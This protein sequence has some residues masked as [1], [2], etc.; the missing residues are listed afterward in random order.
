MTPTPDAPIPLTPDDRLSRIEA[1]LMVL[2]AKQQ[3]GPA[4][5]GYAEKPANPLSFAVQAAQMAGVLPSTQPKRTW[6]DW[7]VIREARLIFGLYFDKRYNPSRAA[8]LG[9]PGLLILIVLSYFF[10]I[11][12]NVFILST[13]L[14]HLIVMIAAVVLYRLVAA[15]LERYA[16]VLDYLE[17]TTVTPKP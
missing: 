3:A 5:V 16:A 11:W 17:R 2:A 10:S 13:I 1:A 4:P 12:F 15:E 14:H 6:K 9:V 7:P 8:Q